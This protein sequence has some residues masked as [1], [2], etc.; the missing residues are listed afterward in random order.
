MKLLTYRHGDH[1]S[2]GAVDA[3]DQV[4]DLGTRLGRPY[5]TLLAVLQN[6]GGLDEVASFI[7]GTTPDLALTDVEYLP[8]IPNPGRMLAIGVNYKDHAEETG[9]VRSATNPSVFLRMP[10]SVVGHKQGILRPRVSTDLDYEGEL[11]IVIGKAGR[12]IS[13]EDALSHIA[14]YSC[15]NDASI[16]DWQ[17]HNPGPT[18]GKNFYRCGSFGPWL[19]T[20]DE[21]GDPHTLDLETRVN[22]NVM[23]KS[24]TSLLIH[25]LRRIVEYCSGFTPLEPGDVISTGTPAGVA[26]GRNPPTWMK[27]GDVVE[28]TISRIGTLSNV[29]EQES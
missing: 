10:S 23:Q 16:R 25:D 5:P 9:E 3:N 19:V 20:A 15:F 24:N 13:R 11:A 17:R 18:P 8:P 1:E 7:A 29:I 27:P 28:V 26:L 14:G 12:Y 4:F 22:G 21:V 2:W 6:P